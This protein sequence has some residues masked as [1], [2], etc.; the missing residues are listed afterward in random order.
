MEIL[1]TVMTCIEEAC[2]KLQAMNISE[3]SIRSKLHP[4]NKQ[5]TSILWFCFVRHMNFFSFPA[6]GITNQRETLIVWDGLTGTPLCN[7]IGKKIRIENRFQ[8]DA[9]I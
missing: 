4:S 2:I 8:C 7:A 3:R 5:L 6:I 1:D 9:I